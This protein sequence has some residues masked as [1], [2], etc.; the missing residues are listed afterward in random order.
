MA[1]TYYNSVVA[2]SYNA[3][4]NFVISNRN[5]GKTWGAQKRAFVRGM[6]HGKR[7]IWVRR[8][9]EEKRQAVDKLYKSQDLCAWINAVWYDTET[10]QGNIRQQGRKF[11]CKRG[12]KWFCFLEV[13]SLADYQSMRSADDVCIDTIVFD[14]FTTTVDR[15]KL[16]KGNEV[17]K[18]LDL[19]YS[20]KRQHIVR[21]W[22]FG[23]KESVSNPYFN[24][25][26]I[27]PLSPDYEGI[28]TYRNGS[29]LIEQINNK[30]II[31][32]EY[33]NKLQSLVDG[34]TYGNYLD[35]EYKNAQ[36]V[37]TSKIPQGAIFYAQMYFD[38]FKCSI[39]Q[40]NGTFYVSGKMRDN[41][42]V[43]CDTIH[44][45][46][47]KERV[48]LQRHKKYF[49]GLITAYSLNK[50]RYTSVVE[51]ESFLLFINWLSI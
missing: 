16:F 33:D 35:S 21:C 8:F 42:I 27:R 4:F 49:T 31:K 3:I 10:K 41:E 5:F 9:H 28:R 24:Y 32:N 47:K 19:F 6:K 13:I 14:E 48:L 40:K 11:Y 20:L 38:G 1:V 30:Q 50:V 2:Q 44:N 25:F 12:G 23:N 37:I 22:F 7:T 36:N 43:Y 17:E 29:V 46:F 26:G 34:T 51:Y 39:M 18:F 15:Y 45:K